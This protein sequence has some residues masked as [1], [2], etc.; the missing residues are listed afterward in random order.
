MVRY[1]AQRILY[2]L[3][4][5]WIVA[6]LTFVMMHAL[7]GDP[8]TSEKAL[9]EAVMQNL[10]ERYHLND[11]LWKQYVDYMKNVATWDLGP[12]FRQSTR[13]V[14]EIINQGFPVSAQLGLMALAVATV[15]GTV[16]GTIAALNRNKWPDHLVTVLSTLG[17]SQPSFIV[18]TLLQYFIALKLQLLPVG[19]WAEQWQ[20]PG[21][22]WKFAVLPVLALSFFPFSYF[23]RLVRSSMLEVLGQD[24][25]RTA[26][27]KGLPRMVRIVK[28]GLR[29]ALLPLITVL[30][31]TAAGILTGSMVIERIFA[32]PGMG[33][34]FV[35]SIFNRDYTVIM[36]FT[37]FYAVLIVFFNL[38]VDL[39]YTLV[40][41]R[42]KLAD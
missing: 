29:N 22:G 30:G 8:F 15:T 6:T 14:N 31:P 1:M 10:R 42:I 20:E 28:H 37:I 9:P 11:P 3:V 12:S 21:D 18:A 16:A 35:T 7:P 38:L 25:M 17:I 23:A 36:G 39:A 33:G 5:I 40:D 4:T 41:P 2:G 24:Y 34:D 26:R 13:T 27:A 19:L 32:I